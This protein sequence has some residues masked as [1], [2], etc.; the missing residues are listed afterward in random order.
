ML[1]QGLDCSHSHGVSV[2]SLGQYP[3]VFDIV[4]DV[5]VSNITLKAAGTGARIK[6]WPNIFSSTHADLAGGGGSGRVRN[7]TWEPSTPS[8]TRSRSTGATSRPT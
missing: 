6:V 5:M 4:E 2:G 3:G 1:I 8:T 7:C